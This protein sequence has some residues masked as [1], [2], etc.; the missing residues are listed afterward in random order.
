MQIVAAWFAVIGEAIAIFPASITLEHPILISG[1]RQEGESVVFVTR[2]GDFLGHFEAFF[3]EE[4]A[5]KSARVD[6]TRRLEFAS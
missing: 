6:Q 2:V 4:I 3:V 1:L 5:A